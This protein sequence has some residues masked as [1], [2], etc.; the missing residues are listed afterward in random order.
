MAYV[1][2]ATTRGQHFPE[3]YCA[4]ET[5]KIINK[6]GRNNDVWE[7]HGYLRGGSFNHIWMPGFCTAASGYLWHYH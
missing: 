3:E 2:Y 4:V 5:V 6:S 1:Q 7:M